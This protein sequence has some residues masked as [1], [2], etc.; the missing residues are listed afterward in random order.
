MEAE[1]IEKLECEV[2][3]S[4]M[5]LNKDQ[6]IEIAAGISL[7]KK[8]YEDKSK[9][10]VLKNI[11]KYI[12]GQEDTLKYELLSKLQK[13]LDTEY[14][15]TEPAVKVKV[16]EEVV[17]EQNEKEANKVNNIELKVEV[18]KTE[19]DDVSKI[20]PVYVAREFKIKGVISNQ[21]KNSLSYISLMRQ[22]KAVEAKGIPPG[23]IMYAILEAVDPNT[24]LRIYL[25]TP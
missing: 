5:K 19:I 8:Y 3:S 11:R 16:K 24:N 18:P 17:N 7:D 21:G 25:D 1:V 9:L 12:D 10:T 22:I 14:S 2:D 23:E 13:V 4:L 6:L 20:K 15:I